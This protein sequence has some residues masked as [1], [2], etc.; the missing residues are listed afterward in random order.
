MTQNCEPY[1]CVEVDSLAVGVDAASGG[2]QIVVQ[3]GREVFPGEGNLSDCHL[4]GRELQKRRRLEAHVM[5]EP[6]HVGCLS[7]LF[8]QF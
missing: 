4:S 1:S 2:S 7:Q 3:A 5:N 6:G 8:D